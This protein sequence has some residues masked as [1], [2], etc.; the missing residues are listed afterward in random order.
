MRFPLPASRLVEEALRHL[1]CARGHAEFRVARGEMD[2][3]DPILLAAEQAHE[4]LRVAAS[5]LKAAD[6]ELAEVRET[7]F[8]RADGCGVQNAAES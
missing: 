8:A 1:A 5:A 2:G 6:A 7:L 3:D 4:L